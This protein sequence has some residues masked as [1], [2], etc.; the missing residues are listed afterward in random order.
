MDTLKAKEIIK[1]VADQRVRWGKL[2]LGDDIPWEQVMDALVWL[3]DQLDI[4][5]HDLV[6]KADLTAANRKLAAAAA[7]ETKLRNDLKELKGDK[8]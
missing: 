7:R 4:M 2:Y 5:Q 8:E 6:P 1:H 3:S